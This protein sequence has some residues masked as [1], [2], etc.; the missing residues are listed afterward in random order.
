MRDATEIADYLRPRV[1]VTG[2][3]VPRTRLVDRMAQSHVPAV[4][5]AVLDGGRVSAAAWGASPDTLF[6]AQSISKPVTAMAVVRLAAE[7]SFTLDAEVNDLLTSWRL[8]DG[9]GEA[10]APRRTG[11]GLDARSSL[12]PPLG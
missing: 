4:S 8:P 11:T 5:V 9:T 12:V 2:R 6:Q 10:A 1:T 3:A 7:G